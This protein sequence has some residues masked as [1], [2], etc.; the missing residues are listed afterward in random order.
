MVIGKKIKLRIL[1]VLSVVLVIF[2]FFVFINVKNKVKTF[3]SN[4]INLGT[5][6][7]QPQNFKNTFPF[8]FNWESV[9]ITFDGT[10]F[11]LK[12]LEINI[13]H[14]FGSKKELLSISIDSVYA[15]IN[16]KE[17]KD[18][19]KNK[20]TQISHPDFWFPFKVSA[21]VNKAVINAKDIGSWSLDS[22]LII[23]PK[24]EKEIFIIAKNIGGSYLARNLFL[25]TSYSW[26][27]NFS[28]ASVLILD[29]ISDSLEI[30]L[31][32]PRESLENLSIEL[33][34]NIEN[35]PFWLNDKWSI[36]AP[37]INN[38]VLNSNI[39]ANI[40]NSKID[41]NLLLNA[42]IGEFW[43]LPSF[44]TTIKAL[45]SDE[46][47]S[48]S[49]IYLK[50]QNKEEIKIKGNV[51]KNLNGN[52]EL[53]IKGIEVTLGPETLPADAKF[54]NITKKGNFVYTNFTTK[55]GSNFDA[56]ILDLNNPVIAFSANLAPKEPWAVQWS[57]DL[58]EL[59][60]PTILTGSFSFK[61][62]ILTANLKTKVP[63]AYYA[64]ADYFEVNLWL[65]KNGIRFPDG[66]I[67]RKG[68][69]STFN[70]EVIWEKEYFTFDLQQPSGGNAK[71]YGT[72]NPKIDL[73]L[74]NIN[75]VQLPFADTTML[76]GYNGIVSGNWVHDFGK[77]VGEA[78]VSLSTVIQDL[79]INAKSDVKIIK[80]SLLVE[81][82]EI[83]QE[84]K[85]ITASMFALLPSETNKSFSMEEAYLNIP[86]M[87]LVSLLATFKDSTLR[88]GIANG[89]LNYNRANGLSGEID[90]LQ[91]ELNK[92][93]S[94]VVK[95][96]N[97]HLE[98]YGDSAKLIS[99]VSL[100]ED[101]FWNGNLEIGI[102]NLRQKK[103]IPISVLYTVKNIDNVGTFKFDG[104]LSE[105]FKK[106]SGDIQIRDDWFL[107]AGIGEIK[108]ANLNISLKTILGKNI[109]DSLTANIIAKDNMFEKNILKIPFA[110]NG[111]IKN[112][113]LLID[114]AFVYGQKDERIEAKLKFDLFDA[115]LKDFNFKTELFTLFLLD[116]HWIKIRNA[117]GKTKLNSDNI[118]IF[119]ELPSINYRM[120][121]ADY[122]T[123]HASIQGNAEYKI[124]FQTEQ[125][126]TNPSITG[127]FEIDK[128]SYNK[129][130]ELLPDPWHLDK[131]FK[132]LTRF[133]SNLMKEKKSGV[134]SYVSGSRPTTLNVKVKTTGREAA[135]VNSNLLEFPFAV[136]LSVL[137]TTRNILL[138]G[139][140]NAVATGKIGYQDY[141]TMFDLSSFRIYWQ[142]EPIRQGKIELQ[143][144]NEYPFCTK[145]DHSNEEFCTVFLNVNG[146]LNKL[147]VQPTTGCNIDTS[148]ATIYYSVLLGCMSRETDGENNFDSDKFFGKVIGKLMTSTGNKVFGQ[149]VIGDIDFKWAFNED[150]KQE[151][152]TNYIRIPVSLSKFIPNLEAVFGYSKDISI[153]T[154]YDKSY[155]VGLRYLLPVFDS[156]DI[157]K[158]F[159]DP[160][161]SINANLIARD[162]NSDTESGNLNDT[163]LEKNVGL[164]YGHKFWD[165]CILGIGRCK[166]SFNS[167]EN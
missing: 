50:G 6:V 131:T 109:M 105:N 57:G 26:D 119:A 93:D 167:E 35:V 103:N 164:T 97:L 54:H 120:E 22:L 102:N 129:N 62:I 96:P 31:N 74:Q 87:N 100:G 148:P 8:K 123:V 147:S 9:R 41:F 79:K 89:S 110:F 104:L 122:G 5:V 69:K 160:S 88:N 42:R 81:N 53:E 19:S 85:R 112:K 108:K 156:T 118:T 98:A 36:E 65:D 44:N 115:T 3:L 165:P 24:K 137:G 51:D 124:P 18:S 59:A 155:E 67:D 144:S 29:E 12:N 4:P 132:N 86:N 125:F 153:D 70:G 17:Q 128:A 39:S 64:S 63:F 116:E 141:L 159:I 16:T 149:N 161:L 52:A 20:L 91:V 47:I 136:S 75:T 101:S 56:K 72:F 28:D 14:T 33:K 66:I 106:I 145:E 134:E 71:V 7:I 32:A 80:D 146:P 45:G 10:N 77:K 68:Y 158:N 90:F 15:N 107:P 60:G 61:D 76:R 78:N 83:E 21:K 143:A 117:S 133:L 151:Q 11:Y 113:M 46:G 157:N 37:S 154:R 139:D 127:N 13:D 58:L 48:K 152:D 82:F 138:N 73:N 1:L 140:I 43:Q 111:H 166:E 135:T 30:I 114:S 38:V 95:F 92:V 126:Q 150:N 162:Y 2:L 23:K 34:A 163:R 27:K 142:D 94:N 130:F 121:S 40:L 55:A 84:E 49:E 99:H 25:N